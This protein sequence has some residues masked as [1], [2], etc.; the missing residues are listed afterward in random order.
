MPSDPP[1]SLEFFDPVTWAREELAPSVLA[2]RQLAEEDG[3]SDQRA[4]FD[5][6]AE[7]LKKCRD[8][9]DL[10]GPLMELS[11][12]AFHGFQFSAAVTFL[13][14]EVLDKASRLAEALSA[15]SES[16]H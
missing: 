9:D 14:D 5:R 2:L 4:F 8:S 15:S 3:Q 6:I 11:T 13:L 16:V 10:A 1:A 7:G 12:S